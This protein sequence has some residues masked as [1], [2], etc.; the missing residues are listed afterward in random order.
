[1]ALF[2]FAGCAQNN[3]DVDVT[4]VDSLAVESDVAQE[5]TADLQPT[6]GNTATG[7]VR[8]TAVDGGVRV[9]A[10]ISDLS[11]GEHGFHIHETG[12][13][14]NNAD[15]AGGHFNPTNAPH[16]GPDNMADARHMG[17]LGNL[18]ADGTYDRVDNVLDFNQII[19]KAVVVHSG[20]DDFTTQPSGDSG[21]RIACGV[22]TMAGGGMDAEMDSTMA[23]PTM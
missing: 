14:S 22:I 6:E 5:A 7:T 16:A 11:D 9:V 8:F 18:P 13:C 4:P 17:D 19:G 3:A 23:T 1:M 21:S 2:F 20:P 10:N 15:A 12:D